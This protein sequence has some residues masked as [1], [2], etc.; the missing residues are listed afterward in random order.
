MRLKGYDRTLRRSRS[1]SLPEGV[2]RPKYLPALETLNVFGIAADYMAQFKDFLE[3]EGLPPNEERVDFFLP[4]I[5]NLGSTPLRTI[6]IK[7]QIDGVNT[8]F[9]DAFRKL[10][11]VPTIET[12]TDYLRKNRVVVNWYPKI[13]ALRS[14]KVDRQIEDGRP[15]ESHLSAQHV[16]FLDMEALYIEVERY[17][18][19]RG[20]YNLNL[21]REAI[22]ELLADRSWYLLQ[23]PED[24][25]SL[26]D[27]E[28]TRVWQEIAVALLRKYLDRYYFFRKRE[29]EL[30]HL[31]YQVLDEKDPNFLVR[32]PGDE[33]GYRISV[34]ASEEAIITKLNELKAAIESGA[35]KEFEFSGLRAIWFDSHLYQPLLHL[36]GGAVEISPVPLNRGERRFVEDL[37]SYCADFPHE[38]EGS[39]LYLL[40]NLSKGRGVGF[41]E[42][43][44]FHPDFILWLVKDDGHQHIIFVDP[45][46]V[47][48]VSFDDPKIRFCE[49]VKDLETRLGN[50]DVSL[51]SYI[52][53]PTSKHAMILHW[54]VSEQDLRD[55]NVLFQ[56]DDPEYVRWMLSEVM[57]PA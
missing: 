25:L 14:R 2:S 31:E 53:S 36:D 33:P 44:N 6:R 16:A 9:G 48:Q 39:E 46:G 38:L 19:D 3:E 23:V 7:K 10:G 43:G 29:W 47:R 51:H 32:E 35:F 40:R 4:V 17:K 42:A 5:R 18:A 26:D 11:P 13:R 1:L 37:K 20:W 28:K 27:F 52:V 15:H 57:E 8:E 49:T 50:P 45:K 30:P 56:D 55:R 34:D 54:N 24:I 21:P 22:P 12:P 41:F